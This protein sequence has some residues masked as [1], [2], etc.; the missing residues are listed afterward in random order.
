MARCSF[1]LRAVAV[2]ALGL[3]GAAPVAA[4]QANPSQHNER[5]E[6]RAWMGDVTFL[7]A[8]ALIAGLTAGILQAVRNQSFQ[9]GFAR[10]AFGGALSYGGRRVAV[11]DFWGAGLL[12]RQISAVGGSAVRNA[13]ESRA[14]FSRVSLPVGPINV[15]LQRYG[16]ARLKAKLD[17]QGAV[18]LLSA[19]IDERLEMDGGASLSAGAP[20]F[21]TPRHRLGLPGDHARGI[22]VGGIIVL[23]YEADKSQN[24]DVFAHERVH[25]LQYDFMQEV[26]GDPLEGWIGNKIPGG[27]SVMRVIRPGVMMPGLQSS[28]VRLLDVQWGDRPWEIEAEYLMHR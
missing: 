4:A 28:M 18:W 22:S 13:S 3:S 16:D 11:E 15:Y 27:R 14:A 26:W 12:G 24:H 6:T 7:S 2:V 25:V 23:G 5:W 17:I 8:N 1:R 20:V 9:D 21:R 19:V 10:G